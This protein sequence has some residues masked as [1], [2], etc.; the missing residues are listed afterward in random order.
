[1]PSPAPR[2]LLTRSIDFLMQ[3]QISTF[4]FREALRMPKAEFVQGARTAGVAVHDALRAA[5]KDDCG[6]TSPLDSMLENGLLVPPLH[7]ALASEVNRGRSEGDSA[8]AL[9]LAELDVQSEQLAETAVIRSLR[10][11]CG[12]Q[13]EL[14][15]DGGYAGMHRLHVGSHL[16]ILDDEPSG[17]WQVSR[18]R[19][20]MRRRGC[21]VQIEVVF[22]SKTGKQQAILCEAC[23]DGEALIAPKG[24]EHELTVRVADLNDMTGGRF[25]NA[26][27]RVRPWWQFES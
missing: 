9:M 8:L 3:P 17:L 2:G 13:R 4:V 12:A 20:L 6:S 25:W 16:V 19:E 23:V 14:A 11:I 24:R 18:Q 5:I 26:A 7:L 27:T 15:A 1:M 21:C 22:G 10:L